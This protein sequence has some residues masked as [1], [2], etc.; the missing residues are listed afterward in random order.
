MVGRRS[1]RSLVPPYDIERRKHF[2]D[3]PRHRG[4]HG[5]RTGLA[6]VYDIFRFDAQNQI[7]L[8]T[9]P[10][11]LALI[12]AA[13]LRELCARD[14]RLGYQLALQVAKLL[15]HRLEGARVQLAAV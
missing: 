7:S 6:E 15:A 8:T 4:R 11:D 9:Q 12:D 13:K 2:G 1:L 14:P 5:G 3:G 10:T